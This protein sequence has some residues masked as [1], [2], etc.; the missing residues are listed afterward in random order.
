MSVPLKKIKTGHKFRFNGV[1]F[2]VVAKRA[3]GTILA[4]NLQNKDPFRI[5]KFDKETP[6]EP[7]D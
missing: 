4:E 6:V 7:A 1:L 2:K 3:F 5:P